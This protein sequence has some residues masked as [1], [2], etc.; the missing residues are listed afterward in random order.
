MFPY[1]WEKYF[2]CTLLCNEKWE[3]N[4]VDTQFQLEENFLAL[5]GEWLS[6]LCPDECATSAMLQVAIW[7]NQVDRPEMENLISGMH[8][9]PSLGFRDD[10]YRHCGRRSVATPACLDT[11]KTSDLSFSSLVKFWQPPMLQT[12]LY[13]NNKRMNN[14]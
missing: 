4:P 8:D 11:L 5:L 14:T 12:I 3:G 9:L 6:V 2:P 7:N 10:K 13:T 1:Y